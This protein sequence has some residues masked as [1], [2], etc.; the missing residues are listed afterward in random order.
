M[1]GGNLGSLLYGDVSVMTK[2]ILTLT[3]NPVITA[4]MTLSLKSHQTSFTYIL[5]RCLMW[6]VSHGVVYMVYVCL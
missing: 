2:F 3:L 6:L 5:S 1:L 4:C